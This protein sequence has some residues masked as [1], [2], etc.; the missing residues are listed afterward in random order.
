MLLVK[1]TVSVPFGRAGA[2]PTAF[3]PNRIAVGK[4]PLRQQPVFAISS[5]ILGCWRR[6]FSQQRSFPVEKDFLRQQPRP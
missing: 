2:S 1:Q 4:E 5:W 3:F 6:I